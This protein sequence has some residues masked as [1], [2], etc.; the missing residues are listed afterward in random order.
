MPLEKAKVGDVYQTR[1]VDTM[2]TPW[3]GGRS[4]QGWTKVDNDFPFACKSIGHTGNQR[5]RDLWQ[6]GR[7]IPA[8]MISKFYNWEIT[9]FTKATFSPE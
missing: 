2:S 9:L 5:C 4:G 1:K 6:Y 3:M 8:I 7:S